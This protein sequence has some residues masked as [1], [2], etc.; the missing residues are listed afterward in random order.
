[1]GS[2]VFARCSSGVAQ[3]KK[4]SSP[5]R[6]A[7]SFAIHQPGFDSWSG[8]MTGWRT[9]TKGSLAELTIRGAS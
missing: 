4:A 9:E 2:M 6:F 7:S 1:M 5:S 8:S 3:G